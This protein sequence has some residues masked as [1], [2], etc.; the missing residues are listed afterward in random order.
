V[1]QRCG[2]ADFFPIKAVV[3]YEGGDV[4]ESLV[5]D[6]VCNGGLWGVD[7]EAFPVVAVVPN[8]VGDCAE[9]LIWYNET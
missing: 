7:A 5:G 1:L 3:V 4:L 6:G 8:K 2:C 9:G